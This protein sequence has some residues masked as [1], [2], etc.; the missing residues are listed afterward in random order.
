VS[1]GPPAAAADTSALRRFLA[2]SPARARSIPWAPVRRSAVSCSC[3]PPSVATF[4]L[5]FAGAAEHP[6]PAI[7]ASAAA[8]TNERSFVVFIAHVSSAA[9]R[10]A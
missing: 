9:R 7:I 5:P 2:G 8:P 4:S 6:A 10:A 3:A 1:C